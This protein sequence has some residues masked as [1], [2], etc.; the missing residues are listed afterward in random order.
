M[1]FL[2][3]YGAWPVAFAIGA[4]IMV[5]LIL[6]ISVDSNAR[7]RQVSYREIILVLTFFDGHLYEL[8]IVNSGQKCSRRWS[9]KVERKN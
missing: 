6:Y 5:S 9:G 1:V 4:F 3:K 8:F 7:R 2:S